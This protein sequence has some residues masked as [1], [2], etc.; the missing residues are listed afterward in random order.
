MKAFYDSSWR[1]GPTSRP[2]RNPFN[3]EIFEEAPDFGP[4]ILDQVLPALAGG[5]AD[6]LD[7]GKETHHAI[8][9]RFAELLAEHA[10]ELIHQIQLEQGK[11]FWEAK[12]EFEGALS[13]ASALADN[14]SLI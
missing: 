6:M 5:A 4:E 13:S 11:P 7:L 3:E 8:F 14:P 12:G 1:A 2:V 9:V 10:E